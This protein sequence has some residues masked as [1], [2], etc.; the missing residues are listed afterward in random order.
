MNPEARIELAAGLCEESVELARWVCLAT[1]IDSALIRRA[2]LTLTR[3]A[4]AGV[5]SDLWFGPLVQTAG[6]RYILF[7]PE[8]TDL[9]RRQLADNRQD[10]ARAWR[11]TRRTHRGLPE[12]VRLEEKLT[13]LALKGGPRLERMLDALLRP[14]IKAML[15]G[16]REGLGRWALNVLPHMPE[17]VR[18]SKS[19]RLLRVVAESQL[20]GGWANLL[21]TAGEGPTDE[22]AALLLHGLE[23]T[24]AGLRLTGDRL[25]VSE[26]P[27]DYSRIIKVPATNPRVLEVTWQGSGGTPVQ[28]R[29]TWQK[30][31]RAHANHVSLPATVNTLA[32]D[33]H[34][35]VRA[36]EV[37]ESHRQLAAPFV[38]FIR[39]REGEPVGM[40]FLIGNNFTL[41]TL[42]SVRN[43]LGPQGVEGIERIGV[44]FAYRE[45]AGSIA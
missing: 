45:Y 1:R 30:G 40:G 25:E 29:L 24:S 43:V 14:L 6:A 3:G 41:T 10:L 9:L 15:T 39:G 11:V 33:T 19:A 35:L 36:V 17:A 37:A 8:V 13:W 20:Y 16:Q 23:R 44:S 22:E 31:E 21:T 27:E 34:R 5:E 38:V 12:L 7:Y 28:S 4:D 18:G 2:R 32:G 42:R 26:P